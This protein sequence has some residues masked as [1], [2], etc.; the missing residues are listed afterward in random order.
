M[1]EQNE[2]LEASIASGLGAL[3]DQIAKLSQ[4]IESCYRYIDRVADDTKSR[5]EYL[6]EQRKITRKDIIQ[7]ERK[8]DNHTDRLKLLEYNYE[9]LQRY[10][11]GIFA[12]MGLLSASEIVKPESDNEQ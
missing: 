10:L 4:Q 5:F 9:R 2:K 3:R 6:Y 8:L 7:I 1:S 12:G 11:A